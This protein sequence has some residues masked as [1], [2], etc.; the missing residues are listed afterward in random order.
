[1]ISSTMYADY[2]KERDGQ[3]V[4]ENADGFAFYRV[5]G[6]ECFI[7]EMYVRPEKRTAGAGRA[8]VNDLSKVAIEEGCEFLSGN[9]FVKSHTSTDAVAAS[10]LS[11]FK[12]VAADNGVISII[13]PLKGSP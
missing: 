10:I 7:A 8:I 6:P 11:G 2:I 3:E 9:I 13:K 12:V 1:M 5:S 4:F